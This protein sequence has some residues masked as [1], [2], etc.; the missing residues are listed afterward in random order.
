VKLYLLAYPWDLPGENLAAC[1]DRF[2]GEVGVSGVS[3]WAAAPPVHELRARDVSPRVFH[4]SGGLLFPPAERFYAK[5]R[6]QPIV[7]SWLRAGNPLKQVADLCAARELEFRAVVSACAS[8]RLAERYP[9]LSSRNCFGDESRRGVCLGNAEV[10]QAL[11]AVLGDLHA[12]LAPAAIVLCDFY[13][14]WSEAGTSEFDAGGVLGAVERFCLGLCFC[15]ACRRSADEAGIDADLARQSASALLQRT[16]LGGVR[17]DRAIDAF[18]AEQPVLIAYRR[19]QNQ[20]LNSLLRQLMESCR[21]PVIVDGGNAQG[22]GAAAPEAAISSAFITCIERSE[23]LSAAAAGGA[24]KNEI[25]LPAWWALGARGPQLVGLLPEAARLG[26]SA[27]TVDHYGI[28]PDAALT[29]L[30]QAIRFSRRTAA[31]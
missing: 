29:T 6:A 13:T 7:S 20:T 11:A 1:L 8:G 26:I 3:V 9:E 17:C 23:Q 14:G 10:Q 21:C 25:R 16:L 27:A 31:A 19:R 2:R 30:K 22:P 12:N 28:L 5:L 15:A 24:A 18:L 4:S